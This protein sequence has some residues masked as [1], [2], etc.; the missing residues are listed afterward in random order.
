CRVQLLTQYFTNST[1][2]LNIDSILFIHINPQKKI[3]PFF[4]VFN[5]YEFEIFLLQIVLDQV[6]NGFFDTG[7]SGS[8]LK[9]S[10]NLHKCK[11]WVSPLFKN[12]CTI[13]VV[14]EKIISQ[15]LERNKKA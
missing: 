13:S 6:L 9:L 7:H 5:F 8:S 10:A 4:N 12:P 3:L 1:A 11:E 15:T 14:Y 2:I